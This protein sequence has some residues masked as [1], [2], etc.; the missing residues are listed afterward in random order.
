MYRLDLNTKTQ[1]QKLHPSNFLNHNRMEASNHKGKYLFIC[2]F[3]V[4]IQ[5]CSFVYEI[6]IVNYMP[7][8]THEKAAIKIRSRLI[9]AE[10]HSLFLT[11]TSTS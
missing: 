10:I 8:I 7:D 2:W 5:L 9:K 1:T 4:G 6:T 11:V 3:L